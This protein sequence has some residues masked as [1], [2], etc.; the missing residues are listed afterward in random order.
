MRRVAFLLLIFVS[1]LATTS[2]VQ[3]QD[4]LDYETARTEAFKAFFQGRLAEGI[5]YFQSA[6]ARAPDVKA[7]L[8]TQRDLLEL[9]GE[10]Y[11]WECVGRTIDAMLPIIKTDR[12]YNVFYPDV[13]LYELRRNRANQNEQ[14]IQQ[15]LAPGQDGLL[16]SPVTHPMAYA[17]YQLELL[18]WE[19]R[20]PNFVTPEARLSAAI[21]A[22]LL[23]DPKEKYQ[24]CKVLLG[25]VQGLYSIR[26]VAGATAVAILAENYFLQNIPATTTYFAE[27]KFHVGMLLSHTN[28]YAAAATAFNDAEKLY[29]QLKINPWIVAYRR[30]TANNLRVVANIFAAHHDEAKAAHAQHMLAP[31]RELLLAETSF[32]DV[33]EFYYAVADVFLS[34]VIGEQP[35]QRW[36]ALMAQPINWATFQLA[37]DDLESYRLFTLAFLTT[38]EE[39]VKRTDLALQAARK[40]TATFD[41]LLAATKEGLILPDF[42]DRM[43]LGV[44]LTAAVARGGPEVADLVLQGSEVYTRAYRHQIVDA[45]AWLAT[46]NDQQSHREAHSFVNLITT[47]RQWEIKQIENLLNARVAPAD[48]VENSVFYPTTTELITSLKERLAARKSGIGIPTVREIQRLLKPTEA[49]ISYFEVLGSRVGKLCVTP[50]K[51]IYAASP[52]DA[53]TGTDIS[54][55]SAALSNAPPTPDAVHQFPVEA[56]HRLYR[57]LFEG[58]EACLAEAQS[59]TMTTP[60]EVA[61]IPMAALLPSL[62]PKQG[63]SY[64]LSK[65]AWMIRDHSFT[66][67]VSAR[68]FVAVRTMRSQRAASRPYLGV[69]NPVLDR[70]ALAANSLAVRALRGRDQLTFQELPET[71]TEVRAAAAIFGARDDDLLLGAQGTEER[72]RSKLLGTYDVIHFATHGLLKGE[73]D[74]LADSALVLSPQNTSD[75]SNDGL[76]S[77]TEIAA[78]SL[79]ARLII[80]S[81]CNTAKFDTAQANRSIQDLQ[82]AFTIAGVPTLVGSLWPVE[83]LATEDLIKRF[84]TRWHANPDAGAA[85][86]LAGAMR[87]YVTNADGIHIHP[88]FWASFVVVGHGGTI[89]APILAAQQTSPTLEVLDAYRSGGEILHAA[90]VDK[91]TVMTLIGDYDGKRMKQFITRRSPTGASRW[92]HTSRDVGVDRVRVLS[93]NVFVSGYHIGDPSYPIIQALAPNGTVR[94]TQRYRDLERYWFADFVA[95][96]D[97]LLAVADPPLSSAPTSPPLALDIGLDG[98]IRHRIPLE[99]SAPRGSV[100]G[101]AVVLATTP[102]RIYAAV[103][104]GTTLKPTFNLGGFIRHCRVDA[105]TDVYEI[106][107]KSWKVVQRHT[108]NGFTTRAAHVHGTTLLLGGEEV[109]DCEGQGRAALY[110]LNAGSPSLRWQDDDPFASS[111]LDMIGDGEHITVLIQMHRIIGMRHH[112]MTNGQLNLAKRAAIDPAI[113]EEAALV[114]IDAEGQIKDRKLY[115]AGYGL[116]LKGILRTQGKIEAYGGLGGIPVIAR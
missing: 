46:Q 24:I 44:G 111:I 79:S 32:K 77:S 9:C 53:Q 67:V 39:R 45:A 55:L 62:P 71:E 81:A 23:I 110:E 114:T 80:L 108:I 15:I 98:R 14:Y 82:A 51:T 37:L 96:P 90:R 3:S 41:A 58:L 54:A 26:D 52:Y 42:L 91:D 103:N 116:L 22:L 48:Q 5:P 89:A 66:S 74:G 75:P 33:T 19:V 106:D 25:L 16:I 99:P 8:M 88:F 7:R 69:G 60:T 21:G 83:S 64:D 27:L 20:Q 113:R 85:E 43:I 6:I 47:K 95:H 72:F 56:S 86:A 115:D 28:A 84:V 87:A 78:L 34:S 94:G 1:L 17:L 29:G 49:F 40:R 30:S 70:A 35:D 10:A 63:E 76:L 73:I 12:A 104:R 65:A 109:N 50:T 102:S 38:P 112:V 107:R 4:Q 59:L 18:G 68:H 92:V 31:T 11:D 57:L 105:A 2:Q 97:G 100:I 93:P 61:A 101:R 36:Q 13:L